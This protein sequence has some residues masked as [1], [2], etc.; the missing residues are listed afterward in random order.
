VI[1]FIELAINTNSQ[2][3]ALANLPYTIG[4]I[5][6]QNGVPLTP[7]TNKREVYGYAI[8]NYLN[9]EIKVGDRP[10]DVVPQLQIVAE[11]GPYGCPR[12]IKT[13]PILR[14]GHPDPNKIADGDDH[15][16]VATAYFCMGQAG[17]APSVGVSDLPKWMRPKGWRP[18]L[19]GL[20]HYNIG[21]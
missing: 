18:D 2:Q 14:V 13:L 7:S 3:S 16:A 9:T 15:W 10:E 8:H 4:D 17:P 6:E 20:D 1:N 21:R 19:S 12:L 11:N 5:F